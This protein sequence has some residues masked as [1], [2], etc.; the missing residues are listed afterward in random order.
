MKITNSAR[1]RRK[2][3]NWLIHLLLAALSFIWILPI[4]WIILTSFRAE[5]GSYVNS[6]FPKSYT[7]DNYVK[8]FT[9]HSVLNFPKM[10]TNTLIIAIFTCLVSTFF[11]LSVSYSLSRLR[12]NFRKPY[13]NLAMI[14]GLF[15]GF[16]AMIAQY[17]ILKTLGLTEGQ[18]VR[19]ALIMVYSAG[20]GLGFQIA[21]GYFDTVPRSIDEAATI[22]GANQWQI[23]T[24]ITIPLSKPI[25]IYTVLTS[26]MGPWVDFIFAKVLIRANSDQF[27]VAIGL[28]NMLQKE[29]IHQWYTAFAAGAVVVSLPIAAL[30]IYMQ[31]FYVEGVS[32][33]VK[34]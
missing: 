24:K 3:T 25:I 9:D 11:V 5:P 18:M 16:M 21:K 31:K 12:F 4:V 29:Y 22:D 27:T 23:F 19:I 32:G 28:W 33:A 30:F 1:M 15:P 26:F 34:G 13:M 8:L 14:L 20:A 6:F 7:L 10:F 17:Y 2:I